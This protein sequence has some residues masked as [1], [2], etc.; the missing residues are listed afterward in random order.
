MCTHTKYA[1]K[2]VI[3]TCTY[4]QTRPSEHTTH[5][6]ISP[7]VSNNSP[8]TGQQKVNECRN[9]RLTFPPC[10]KDVVICNDS[11]TKTFICATMH[12]DDSC[13]NDHTF[14]FFFLITEHIFPLTYSWYFLFIHPFWDEFLSYHILTL[15]WRGR[16]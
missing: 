14:S 4:T 2:R 15:V 6:L 11:N 8:H 12:N 10:V 9:R 3:H 7:N 1:R 13:R 16:F 5:T